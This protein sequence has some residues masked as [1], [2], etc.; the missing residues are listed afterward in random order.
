MHGAGAVWSRGVYTVA[1]SLTPSRIGTLTPH[2]HW[3]RS[4]SDVV[5]AWSDIA[6]NGK[7]NAN[8]SGAT[9]VGLY[10][11]SQVQVVL[12]KRQQLPPKRGFTRAPILQLQPRARHQHS[13]KPQ[14]LQRRI[15]RWR[16]RQEKSDSWAIRCLKSTWRRVAGGN[17]HPI[18]P[19]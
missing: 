15:D 4:A 2:C 13:L 16:L 8:M 5:G 18:W 19:R 3:T 9:W 6:T 14:D 7:S 11:M 1:L 17:C 12:N 10:F